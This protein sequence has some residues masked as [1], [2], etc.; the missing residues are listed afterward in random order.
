MR[1]TEFIQKYLGGPKYPFCDANREA[2]YDDL[3]AVVEREVNFKKEQKAFLVE[4]ME[5]DEKGGIYKQYPKTPKDAFPFE[6]VEP[7]TEVVLL[8]DTPCCPYEDRTSGSRCNNCGDPPMGSALPKDYVDSAKLSF[9]SELGI[10]LTKPFL[11]T[12]ED[13]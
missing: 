4:M 13:V 12:Q 9:K 10:S 5:E 6:T 3:C 1:K 2:M 7:D 11:D 8:N